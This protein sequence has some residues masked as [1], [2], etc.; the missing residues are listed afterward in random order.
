MSATAEHELDL[1]KHEFIVPQKE[2]KIPA[3]ITEKWEKSE[4][5]N[6]FIKRKTKWINI[7]GWEKIKIHQEDNV[8][9]IKQECIPAGCGTARTWT[10][11][12]C[13]LLPGGGGGN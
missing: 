6:N 7:E 13:S 1:E 9:K 12:P 2:V 11:L 3:D 8:S 4:V 10:V 5:R